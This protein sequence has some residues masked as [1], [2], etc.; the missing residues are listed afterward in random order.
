MQ[1]KSTPT[2]LV[3]PVLPLASLVGP[4]LPPA[5]LV[6]PVLPLASLVGP[7]LPQASSGP[8]MVLNRGELLYSVQSAEGSRRI[9]ILL[10]SKNHCFGSGSRRLK[11]LENVQVH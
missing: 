3:G 7:V 2:S 9:L 11:S 10:N 1:N 6:G 4:V 8:R 5:S